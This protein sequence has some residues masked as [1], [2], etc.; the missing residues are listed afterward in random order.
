MSEGGGSAVFDLSGYNNPIV[1]TGSPPWPIG[2][3]GR[4]VDFDGSTDSGLVTDIPAH[5]VVSGQ[6]FC[7]SFW[8]RVD[9]TS[10]NRTALSKRTSN[11]G[12][13]F[14]YT[15]GVANWFFRMDNGP[16]LRDVTVT[17]GLTLGTTYH[18]VCG[19]DAASV[20]F[21]YVN[22]TPNNTGAAVT[23]DITTAGVNLGIGRPSGTAI[24]T[25]DGGLDD[26]RLYNRTLTPAE[27]KSLYDDP[28]LEFRWALH[29][30]LHTQVGPIA[31]APAGGP[32]VGSLS[33]VGA[34][35]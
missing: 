14:Q 32:P 17:G 19:R 34:G 4:Y 5:Q 18:I 31:V 2:P 27:I 30:L 16:T 24:E 22:G 3:A 33:L 8:L 9:N 11:I 25:L 1:L 29:E 10:S 20:P 21:I 15:T 7:V 26:I 35:V 28:Q 12:W 23:G 13:A 6:T